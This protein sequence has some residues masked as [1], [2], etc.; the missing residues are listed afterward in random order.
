MRHIEPYTELD[1]GALFLPVWFPRWIDRLDISGPAFVGRSYLVHHREHAEFDGGNFYSAGFAEIM[2]PLLRP[3][4]EIKAA[5]GKR[6]LREHLAMFAASQ[7]N[8]SPYGKYDFGEM[9]RIRDKHRL[10][11]DAVVAQ[12][13]TDPMN[14]AW[15]GPQERILQAWTSFLSHNIEPNEPGRKAAEFLEQAFRTLDEPIRVAWCNG[16]REAMGGYRTW[17]EGVLRFLDELPQEWLALPPITDDVRTVIR[18]DEAW[19][20]L[21]TR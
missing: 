5:G 15:L 8:D 12:I 17:T 14:C 18:P 20:S 2:C 3:A 11:L 13:D 4:D 19:L 7:T 21:L 6:T 10:L 16:F 1:N 9:V